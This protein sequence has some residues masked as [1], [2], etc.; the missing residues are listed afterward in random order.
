MKKSETYLST[1][2][3]LRIDSSPSPS[4]LHSRPLTPVEPILRSLR[5]P[6]VF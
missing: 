1:V 3:N 6:L 4:F 5:L 2:R